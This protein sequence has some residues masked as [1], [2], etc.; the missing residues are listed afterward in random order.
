MP[1]VRTVKRALPVL[2]TVS[3]NGEIGSLDRLSRT[4]DR[5]LTAQLLEHLCCSCKSVSRL[6]D[7]DIQDEFLDA[8]FTHRVAALVLAAAS[9]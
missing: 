4:V 5:C 6:A 3:D 9:T 7:R 2:N 1:N 8:K